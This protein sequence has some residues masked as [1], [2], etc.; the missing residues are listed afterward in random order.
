MFKQSYVY[1]NEYYLTNAVVDNGRIEPNYEN[2][3]SKK[4][5]YF[6]TKSEVI[7]DINDED[8]VA[9]PDLTE[10]YLRDKN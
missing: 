4:E 7:K 6:R 2:L 9:F 10:E 8:I 5:V 3:I 1:F